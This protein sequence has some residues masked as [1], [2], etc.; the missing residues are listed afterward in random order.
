MLWCRGVTPG[1]GHIIFQCYH[2]AGQW[3]PELPSLPCTPD[4]DDEES[5]RGVGRDISIAAN[6]NTDTLHQTLSTTY[7]GYTAQGR[8]S[9][10]E[11][12]R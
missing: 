1:S 4:I 12:C 7:S 9:A 2:R 5:L 11:M 3:W 10:V 6:I 8:C